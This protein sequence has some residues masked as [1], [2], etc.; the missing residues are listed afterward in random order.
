MVKTL[1]I[2]IMAALPACL[3]LRTVLTIDRTD[4]VRDCLQL[5]RECL[6]LAESVDQTS[7]LAVINARIIRSQHCLATWHG[8]CDNILDYFKLDAG[9]THDGGIP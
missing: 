4:A 9:V 1:I 8:Q 5:E 6:L 2:I 7:D 3:Q